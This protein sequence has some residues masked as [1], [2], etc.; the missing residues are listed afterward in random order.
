MRAERPITSK[1]RV[2]RAQQKNYKYMLKKLDILS[3]KGERR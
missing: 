2:L 3:G 1:T